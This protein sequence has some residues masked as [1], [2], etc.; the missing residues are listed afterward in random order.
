[1]IVESQQRKSPKRWSGYFY[2]I[3]I[4]LCLFTIAPFHFKGVFETNTV[5]QKEWNNIRLPSWI[6]P[7]YYLL[8]KATNLHDFT[9]EGK[10]HIT[11]EILKKT[12]IIVLH[13]KDLEVKFIDLVSTESEVEIEFSHASIRPEYDQM[14]FFFEKPLPVGEYILSLG[15]YGKLN[16]NMAGYYLASYKKE[17]E[18]RY[19]A[20]TQFEDTSARLAF[21]CFDEPNKKAVF[22][23]S[24]TVD[25]QY[26]TLSNMQVKAVTPIGDKKL[27]EFHPTVRMSTYLVAF[28]VSD[29]ESISAKT[30]NG[31]EVSVFTAPGSTDL[32]DYAL[33]VGVPI[34]EYFEDV[35][36]IKYPLPKLDMIAIPDFNAGAMENWGLITYRDTA[37]LFDPK[38]STPD[39]KQ[40]VATVVAHEIS[41]QWFGNLV[42]MDWWNDL[43]LNEGFARF[44]QYKGTDAV[45]PHWNMSDQF[46]PTDFV[47]ALHADES[48]FSHAITQKVENPSEKAST[49]ILYGKGSSII[50]MLE[51]WMNE[52]YGK[53]LFFSKLHNYLTDHAYGNA[54]TQ[55]LWDALR[56]DQDIGKF[57]HGWTDQPG[58]PFLTF[59]ELKTGSVKVKQERFVFSN[60]VDDDEL[61]KPVDA[62]NFLIPDPADQL[63]SVPLSYAVYSN[64]TGIPKLLG[65]GFAEIAKQGK[66]AVK[67]DKEYPADSILLANFQQTGFYR[68][69]Y[70]TKTYKY[71]IEWLKKDLEFLPAVERA[72]LISDVFSMTFTGRLEDST[73]A[74]DLLEILEQETNVLVWETALKDMETLKNIFAIYPTYGPL[75]KFQTSIIEKVIKHIG[76][77]E[78]SKDTKDHHL[79]AKLRSRLF[80]E[81]VRNNH[82]D[83]VQTAVKYFRMIK[84]GKIDQLPVKPDVYGAIYDAGVL[85]GDLEDYEFV[86][87]KFKES[88]FAPEQQIYLHALASTATPY[89]QARTLSFAIGGEVRKQ[90]IP[91][92]LTQV[93]T[94]SPVGH[95]SVWLFL[96]DSWDEIV[97]LKLFDLN[98]LLKSVVESFTK[99][100][101]IAEAENLFIEMIDPDFKVPTGSTLAV[102]KGLETARQLLAWRTLYGHQVAEWLEN[103]AQ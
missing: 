11:I 99:P 34:L 51:S 2:G 59:A 89:L 74:L 7:K 73:I 17:G 5:V 25:S 65:R 68:S 47:K 64:A 96:L 33:K 37:L 100:F 41:H 50:R 92:L 75:I 12:E 32:G 27:Y 72:G 83:S 102:L 67:F 21:P 66:V 13:Q 93:A 58:F 14:S 30:K 85:Y 97:E 4:A 6:E 42:T 61:K 18:T 54:H 9:F 60:L 26:H 81:A 70:N 79:R 44:M 56:T 86:L 38:R 23:I 35:F 77:T 62:L 82:K 63:W 15:Y 52:K 36:D 16:Q 39:N 76:W 94:L 53:E 3:L 88:T 87:S 40:R 24:M 31:V 91:T 28:I 48:L 29:F 95:I 45:E 20:T 98:A 101:L 19:L 46:I 49:D 10:V 57:M 1:M 22:E 78:T 43:W 71:V 84:D 90:D 80:S 69:L 55:E 8:D 103:R